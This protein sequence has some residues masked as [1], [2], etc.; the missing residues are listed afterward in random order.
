MKSY[1]AYIRV[2]TVRQGE[3]GSS[4]VEQRS[5]IESYAARHSLHISAWYEEMETAAKQGRRAFGTMIAELQKKQTAGVIIHKIDR[6]ARNLRDWSQIADLMDRGIEVHCAHD[7]LE[8]NTRGGRLS[9]DIQAVIAAD[10][11]RN[12]RDEVVKGIYGRLKQGIWPF[13]APYGYIN[14]GS[15]RIKEIDPVKGALVREAFALYASGQYPLDTLRHEMARR[16]LTSSG[17]AFSVNATAQILRNPFYMGILRVKR[18][19]EHF[20]GQHLPLISKALFEQAQAVM[21]GRLYKGSSKYDFLFS[22]R[23]RC[24]ACG[25][26]LVGE[27]QRGHAY[28]RCH[29]KSCRGTSM[30]EEA[31]IQVI[32]AIFEVLTYTDAEMRDLRDLRDEAQ[33]REV[34]EKEVW[35]EQRRMLLAR[36]DD[37]RSR[38]TDAYL[39]GSLDKEAYNVRN[40][41]LLAERRGLLDA[42]ERP[43]THGEAVD[44]LEK[45]EHGNA[46]ILLFKM[47][48]PVEKQEALD[49]IV[50]NIYAEAKNPTFKLKF[51]FNEAIKK[52]LLGKGGP[53]RIQVRT[54]GL[55][56][57][58]I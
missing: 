10:Y 57:R 40:T 43:P 27:R 15:A 44:R 18:T 52:R 21:D 41:Q 7:S 39:D 4:L 50:S 22:R 47:A 12:L 1:F 56:Q 46:S 2:S 28:Y 31:V 23:I 11:I 19:G 8:L 53:H 35:L 26:S 51:P 24:A 36:C 13:P 54:D 37:R 49:L 58:V 3:Q 38:L 29:T 45:L 16:G 30:N 42:L 33:S 34:S 14:R 55:I 32:M 48:V 9:A 25:R 20:A 6:S 5:A 17:R